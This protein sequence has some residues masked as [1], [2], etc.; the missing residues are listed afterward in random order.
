M[1]YLLIYVDDILIT[2]NNNAQL[3][4]F[5]QQLRQK[6]SMKDLRPLH[7]FLGMDV[8]RIA[9][10]MYLTQSKYILDRLKK[11]NMID[12][13]PLSTPVSSGKRLSLYER[14]SLSNGTTFHSVVG[15]LKYLLFTH[16]DIAFAINQVC[17][18]MHSPTI[19]H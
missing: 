19:A 15:A 9:S 1:I 10:Y 13:K 17:Q 7:Y 4:Q 5:I 12:V 18:C 3:A 2:C 8:Q 11:M 14:E 6:F 16:P